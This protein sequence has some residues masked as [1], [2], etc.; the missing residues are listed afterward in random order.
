M[1]QAAAL[2][3]SAKRRRSEYFRLE[4]SSARS[5]RLQSPK[6]SASFQTNA[7]LGKAKRAVVNVGL[8]T[9]NRAD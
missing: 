6:D 2:A 1:P 4:F 8:S 3:L 7:R 9:E 5:D